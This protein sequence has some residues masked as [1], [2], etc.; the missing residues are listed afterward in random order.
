M[1][2]LAQCY[3]FYYLTWKN[4]FRENSNLV[5]NDLFGGE[6]D[7]PRDRKRAAQQQHPTDVQFN[8]RDMYVKRSP[9]ELEELRYQRA[10]EAQKALGTAAGEDSFDPAD[11]QRDR[12]GKPD[13]PNNRSR[14][15]GKNKKS[16]DAATRASS[17]PLPDARRW[18]GTRTTSPSIVVGRGR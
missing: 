2:I 15:R 12:G 10:K 6:N 4:V 7:R 11:Y 3:Y 17:G 9:E 13:K 16:R 1:W 14:G 5:Y 8:H 18:S